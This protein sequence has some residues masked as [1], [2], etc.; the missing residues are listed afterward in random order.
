MVPDRETPE[1]LTTT[2]IDRRYLARGRHDLDE[3]TRRYSGLDASVKGALACPEI[4][5]VSPPKQL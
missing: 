4:A 1:S 3:D 5:G 2:V